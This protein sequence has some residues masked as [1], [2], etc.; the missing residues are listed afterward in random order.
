MIG[1][2]DA[3]VRTMKSVNISKT[4][5]SYSSKIWSKLSQSLFGQDHKKNRHWLWVMWTTNRNRVRDLVTEQ[6]TNDPQVMNNKATDCKTE[7]PSVF[8]TDKNDEERQVT[9]D[10]QQDVSFQNIVQVEEAI[11]DVEVVSDQSDGEDEQQNVSLQNIDQVEEAITDIVVVSD[12]S[13]GE[14]EQQN[15]DQEEEAFTY[16]ENFQVDPFSVH[17]NR[18]KHSYATPKEEDSTDPVD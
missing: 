14:D 3:L 8:K 15:I 5:T 11:T 10:E 12:Q 9:E 6:Q 13:D 1:G 4:D 2:I 7:E 17:G 18:T 16:I